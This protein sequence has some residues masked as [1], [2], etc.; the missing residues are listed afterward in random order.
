MITL[1]R[2]HLFGLLAA[3]LIVRPGILM[4][5]KAVPRVVDWRDVA[6]WE[7]DSNSGLIWRDAAG[8]IV[9][10]APTFITLVTGHH[11]GEYVYDGAL[12][13]RIKGGEG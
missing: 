3:P 2:R 6:T 1:T 5:V 12:W 8:D 7:F 4:P 9:T 10:V 13:H 11:P